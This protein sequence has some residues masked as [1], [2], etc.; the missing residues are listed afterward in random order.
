MKQVNELKMRLFLVTLSACLLTSPEPAAREIVQAR[1]TASKAPVAPTVL[2]LCPH[3][4]AKSVLASAYF[5]R[6]AKER[7]LNVRVTSAGTEPDPT[8]AP[9]VAAHLGKQG[10]TVPTTAPRKA[11]KEDLATAD[12]VVSIG[13]DLSGLPAPRGALVKWD[14]VPSPSQDFAGADEAIRKRVVAL[15]EELA[16]DPL[17]R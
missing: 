3:G 8:V 1:G 15:I 13:C 4:A 16:R 12:V 5:Q 9:A 14:D 7:G 17:F 10:Y 11:S 2:F 6:L